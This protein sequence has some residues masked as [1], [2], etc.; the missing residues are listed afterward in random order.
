MRPLSHS[1]A[2]KRLKRRCQ[3]A[4]V[5]MALPSITMALITPGVWTKG[6]RRSVAGKPRD[7]VMVP[8]ADARVYR[9]WLIKP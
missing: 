8:F 9:V 4:L 6:P 2:R 1:D 7:L 5:A 3:K